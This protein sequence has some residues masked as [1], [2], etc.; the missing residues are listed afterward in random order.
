MKRVIKK[1][2][3]ISGL[4]LTSLLT[5]SPVFAET[6]TTTVY[7][8]FYSIAVNM[9]AAGNM[10][11]KDKAFA[12]NIQLPA[13]CADRTFT[14][15]KTSDNES[16]VEN[17]LTADSTGKISVSLYPNDKILI[18]GLSKAEIESLKINTNYGVS[19]ESYK[20]DGYTTTYT[21]SQIEGN[22]A[23]TV[24]NSRQS[25]VPSGSHIAT[26]VAASCLIAILLLGL[27]TM[28]KRTGGEADD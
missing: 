18:E 5:I 25:H 20:T 11:S 7:Q 22:L 4:I 3:L 14:A 27:L 10:A 17:T 12:V 23:V 1:I 21:T 8:S 19:E 13:S 15:A 9:T 2:L 16:A 26:G 6:Q 24:T 28:H